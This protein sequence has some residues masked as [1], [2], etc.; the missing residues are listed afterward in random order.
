MHPTG[1]LD[2]LL[3]PSGVKYNG[4]KSVSRSGAACIDW[5]D[6]PIMTPYFYNFIDGGLKEAKNY[7]RNPLPGVY[8]HPWCYTASGIEE[9]DI[10]MC[11]K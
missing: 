8:N 9:C 1:T 5:F 3:E 7:C 6:A 2:C 11:G 4:T 10:D